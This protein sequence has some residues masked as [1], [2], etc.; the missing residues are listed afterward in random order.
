MDQTWYHKGSG[1]TAARL[2]AR[3]TD[4]PKVTKVSCLYLYTDVILVEKVEDEQR[5]LGALEDTFQ[6]IKNTTGL[7]DV[8]DIIDR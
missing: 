5:Q 2:S 1:T 6:Q 7:S 3:A 8:D 4:R